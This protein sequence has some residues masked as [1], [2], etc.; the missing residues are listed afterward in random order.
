M[1]RVDRLMKP[2]FVRII[3]NRWDYTGEEFGKAAGLGLFDAMDLKAMRYWVVA[4]PVCSLHCS[5][6]HNE[7]RPFYFN[8]MG[9]LIRHKCPPGISWPI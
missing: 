4:K 6:C 2:M 9:M 7:G 3:K 8:A 1:S 5:G